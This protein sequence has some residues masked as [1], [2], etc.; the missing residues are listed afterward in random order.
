MNLSMNL[1]S[2]L[3][4]TG[5]GRRESCGTLAYLISFPTGAL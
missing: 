5:L 3:T 1:L 4:I 2:G